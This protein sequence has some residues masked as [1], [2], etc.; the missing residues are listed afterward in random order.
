MK[1]G[2]RVI[3]GDDFVNWYN[4][5]YEKEKWVKKSVEIEG[6]LYDKLKKI[7]NEELD[8]SVN[9]IIDACIDDFEIAEKVVIYRKR[10]DEINVA[11]SIIIRESIY[12]KLED[13][14]EKYG[15]SISKLV[16]IAIRTGLESYK[17][18]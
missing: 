15:I 7:A 13:M 12:K 3:L 11:R 1:Y 5:F 17:N 16:N 8:A 10:K 6:N 2:K 9:K 18:K 4:R 14:R